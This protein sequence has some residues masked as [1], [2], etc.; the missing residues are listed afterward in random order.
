MITDNIF[1]LKLGNRLVISTAGA[2][3]ACFCSRT[4]GVEIQ[5]F[6]NRYTSE[7]LASVLLSDA[8]FTFKIFAIVYCYLRFV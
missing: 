3:R 6:P 1:N 2:D 8:I 5:F 4:D 7:T